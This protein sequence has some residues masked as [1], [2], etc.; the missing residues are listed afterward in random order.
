MVFQLK[1]ASQPVKNCNIYV[2]LTGIVN[3]VQQIFLFLK[4]MKNTDPV[5]HAKLKSKTHLQNMFFNILSP[6][7]CSW[8][9]SLKKV[10]IWHKTSFFLKS[11]NRYKKSRLLHCFQICWKSVKKCTWKKLSILVIV[12]QS[13]AKKNL[14]VVF[15][16]PSFLNIRW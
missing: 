15:A 11:H 4:K 2:Q 8:L 3:R 16:L 6:F 12:I 7:L 10:L 14:N 5:M 13:V 9:Q 1:V